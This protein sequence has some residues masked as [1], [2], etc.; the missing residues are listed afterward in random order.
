MA[1]IREADDVASVA[2]VGPE[3]E[4]DDPRRIFNDNRGNRIETKRHTHTHRMNK[5]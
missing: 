2:V 3:L 5:H 1:V 4:C